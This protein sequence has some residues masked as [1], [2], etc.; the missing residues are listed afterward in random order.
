M[1]EVVYKMISLCYS[2][3]FHNHSLLELIYLKGPTDSD[4]WR[5]FGFA[6]IQKTKKNLLSNYVLRALVHERLERTSVHTREL[7]CVFALS[8]DQKTAMTHIWITPTHSITHEH[9]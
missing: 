8:Q 4:M 5:S 6:S 7:G 2:I 3:L 9:Q 1:G